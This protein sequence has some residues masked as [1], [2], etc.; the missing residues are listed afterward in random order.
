MDPTLKDTTN[1]YWERNELGNG[2][3]ADLSENDFCKEDNIECYGAS[4]T[5]QHAEQKDI[6][7]YTCFAKNVLETNSVHQTLYP[8][9]RVSQY[10]T[11]IEFKEGLD[12]TLACNIEVTFY[13]NLSF[14]N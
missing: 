8:K 5:I 4:V 10:D 14:M 13:Q 7:I 2:E 12:Q 9:N 6:G 11:N 3:R 1:I